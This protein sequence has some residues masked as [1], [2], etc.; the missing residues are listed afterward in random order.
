MVLDLLFSVSCFIARRL[1]FFS[2]DHCIVSP[3]IYGASDY[4]FDIYKL[5]TIAMY[6]PLR[7]TASDY[8]IG[9]F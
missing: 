1:Y 9:I 8:L 6:V 2:F 4:S 7:F 3:A 5:L